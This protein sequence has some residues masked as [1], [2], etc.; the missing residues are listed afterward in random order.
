ML[1]IYDQSRQ[2][3]YDNS[4][5]HLDR[6]SCGINGNRVIVVQSSSPFKVLSPTERVKIAKLKTGSTEEVELFQSYTYTAPAPMQPVYINI[7]SDDEFAGLSELHIE[8]NEG[9]VLTIQVKTIFEDNSDRLTVLLNNNGVRISDIWYKAL[10]SAKLDEMNYIVLNKKRREFL[11]SLLELTGAISGYNNL[12]A[13]LDFFEW[14]D[15]ITVKEYWRDGQLDKWRI[16]DVNERIVDRKLLQDGFVKEGW[17][18]LYFAMNEPDGTF[19]SDGFANFTDVT[20]GVEDA[21][22]KLYYLKQ[23]LEENFLGDVKV[24]DIVGEFTGIAGVDT[25]KW[26]D[27]AIITS[28]RPNPKNPFSGFSINTN[29]KDKI[30]IQDDYCLRKLPIFAAPNGSIN[31]DPTA[32]S[33]HP[34][35]VIFKIEQTSAQLAGYEAKDLEILTKFYRG[36]FANIKVDFN[37][38]DEEYAE[39]LSYKIGLQLYV[40]ASDTYVEAYLSPL[41]SFGELMDSTSLGIKRVGKFRLCV[42]MFDGYGGMDMISSKLGFEV[43]IDSLDI[44]LFELSDKIDKA[45]KYDIGFYTTI[46]TNREELVVPDAF[47][48]SFDIGDRTTAKAG[49]YYKNSMTQRQLETTINQ[50][51]MVENRQL[52]KARIIDYS[53][54]HEV[55]L[56]PFQPHITTFRMKIFERHEYQEVK[57]TTITLENKMDFVSKLNAISHRMGGGWKNP[58]N[59]YTYHLVK[60]SIDGTMDNTMDCILAFSKEA[61]RFYDRII[62]NLEAT[63]L[64][65]SYLRML[66]LQRAVMRVDRVYNPNKGLQMLTV[67]VGRSVTKIPDIDVQVMEQLEVHL[68]DIAG[69]STMVAPNGTLI[70]S[71][72]EDVMISHPSIGTHYEIV[73][74]SAYDNI[75]RA[76]IGQ[77]FQV[78]I[79][80]MGTPVKRNET[81][82]YLWTIT[83]RYTGD[84]VHQ[85]NNEVLCWL[86]F[87][88]GIYDVKLEM[89]DALNDDIVIS[90][91]KRG[92][93][94]IADVPFHETLGEE[95]YYY[96]VEMERTV[97][98]EMCTSLY[99]PEPLIYK[100]PARKYQSTISQEDADKRA[101]KEI[102]DNAQNWAN[103]FGS[104]VLK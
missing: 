16:T 88:M 24:I 59:R 19:D 4:I 43:G 10:K 56:F 96:N 6:I 11:L 38:D 55:L 40:P 32:T 85:E 103:D 64:E 7:Y 1:R 34:N 95:V 77:D 72:K 68:R 92:G 84:I 63:P 66:A 3:L 13:V 27:K 80:V 41:M 98:S 30:I 65:R 102:E 36:D 17:I 97:F 52:Q 8:N 71:A 70:V 44:Q 2:E 15:T 79:P 51:N 5:L 33:A 67:A 74:N 93:I 21:W 28:I 75:R 73:R 81:Y 99:E 90:S 53:T 9:N 82:D 86:P 87:D 47:D 23:I 31:L 69:L 50:Y 39:T 60:Y 62:H 35:D 48:T 37:I 49:R 18:G 58:F 14:S 46:P 20:L 100:V 12:F 94:R 101:L 29:S 26:I 22:T 78:T 83:N 25:D 104:C 61:D 54:Y 76:K 42:Y 45:L 89:L 91:F 57:G